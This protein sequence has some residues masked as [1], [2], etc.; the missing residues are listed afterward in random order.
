MVLKKKNPENWIAINTQ[1][2]MKSPPGKQTFLCF[3]YNLWVRDLQHL[4][5]V[6][7]VSVSCL[8]FQ[9]QTAIH[10]FPWWVISYPINPPPRKILEF[11]LFVCFCCLRI[12]YEWT[13]SISILY[14]IICLLCEELPEERTAAANC[15][16]ARYTTS[17]HET[18]VKCMMYVWCMRSFVSMKRLRV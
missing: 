14:N 7:V 2:I 5:G 17:R 9:P 4:P 15:N 16:S 6:F 3:D 8:P 10:S 11:T 1:V 18:D 13:V 12:N